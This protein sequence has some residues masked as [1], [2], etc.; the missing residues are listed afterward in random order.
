MFL[1]KPFK[2][3]RVAVFLHKLLC[4]SGYV[5]YVRK[6]YTAETARKLPP[7]PARSI[8]IIFID[9]YCLNR[10]WYILTIYVYFHLRRC[11]RK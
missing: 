4:I 8:D 11:G 2:V 5:G 7:Q 6:A 3:L 1:A 9:R 10:Y